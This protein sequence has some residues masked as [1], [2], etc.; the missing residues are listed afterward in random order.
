MTE[1]LT[2]V[3][4]KLIQQWPD[5]LKAYEA[6]FYEYNVRDKVIKQAMF[7]DQLYPVQEFRKLYCQ[8]LKTGVIF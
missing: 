2:P 1:Q 3:S 5:K 7:T 4:R 8:N 6:E